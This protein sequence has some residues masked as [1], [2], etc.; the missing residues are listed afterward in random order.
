MK[1]LR[2]MRE[3]PLSVRL[4]L[5]NQF[6]VNTGFYLLIPY[7]A[8]YLTGEVGLSVAV[9]AVVLAVRNLSQQGLFL[10]G[11]S[12]SD[13]LGA[14]RV[15]IAGCGLRAVGFALFALG[16]S[17]P[18]LLTAAVLSGMAGA[19]FN[20]A[21]RAYIAVEAREDR[22]AAAFALFQVFA[23]AGALAGPVLGSV[24]LLLNFRVA[25]VSAAVI[26]AGLTIAQALV[27]PDR[28][29][30]A[31]TRSVFA[32]WRECVT[33]RRF[34]SF[35]VAAS[36]LFA[37]Q[38]QLYLVLPMEAERLTG[39]PSTVAVLFVTSTVVTLLWQ[40]RITERFAGSTTRGRAIAIGM[41]LMGAGFVAPALAYLLPDI[42][43]G[44][45]PYWELA[46]RLLPVLAATLL[47]ALGVMIVQPF[48]N[49]LI[50]SFGRA[51]MTGTYFGMFYLTSGVVA[52]V[53]T[54]VIGW[55]SQLGGKPTG[56]WGAL[57]CVGIGLT[58]AAGVALLDRRGALRLVRPAPAGEVAG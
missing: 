10:I 58:S 52:A 4:L 23:Q 12:A 33:N 51:E 13:R 44:G 1:T 20:P 15:I 11:G 9:V 26:F 7:L 49:E 45:A 42:T 24:L 21:V 37:L 25:A 30:T 22:R 5:V 53:S 34:L 29:V 46:A 27:L 2:L 3:F 19:L 36:G 43:H 35:T 47:L 14:R 16:E 18:L 55:V 50:P 54:A 32:D 28:A 8:T 41:A 56:W 17:V 31:S 48:V 39:W 40:V 38:N 57:V 6:G